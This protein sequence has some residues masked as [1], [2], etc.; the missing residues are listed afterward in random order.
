MVENQWRESLPVTVA[1][2][3]QDDAALP[4]DH[5]QPTPDPARQKERCRRKR[6]LQIQIG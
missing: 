5:T 1:N 3:P 4:P 2:A 6:P